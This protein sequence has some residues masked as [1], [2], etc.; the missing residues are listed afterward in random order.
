MVFQETTDFTLSDTEYENRSNFQKLLHLLHDCNGA[1]YRAEIVGVTI[2]GIPDMAVFWIDSAA[3][4]A[5]SYGLSEIPDVVVPF[6]PEF[7]SSTPP[8]EE[9]NRFL[10]HDHSGDPLIR[11]PT[12]REG[13][14]LRGYN[15]E[16]L[17]ALEASGL[18]E[19]VRPLA[20]AFALQDRDQEMTGS[21]RMATSRR[22]FR[23]RPRI[24]P[25]S[26]D[27]SRYCWMFWR[28]QGWCGRRSIY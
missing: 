15:G 12:G 5:W 22:I 10:I 7:T 8:A 19:A 3:G 9:V 2:F 20:R 23:E 14:E 1:D 21:K 26:A 28:E 13:R 18:L 16:S 6:V 4:D 11:N 27:F 25:T 24:V 17:L